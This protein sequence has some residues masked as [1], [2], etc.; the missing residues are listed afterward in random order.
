MVFHV[1]R[2]SEIFYFL[3]ILIFIGRSFSQYH[4]HQSSYCLWS[5]SL[6]IK[7]LLLNRFRFQVLV[8]WVPIANICPFGC[9]LLLRCLYKTFITIYISFNLRFYLLLSLQNLRYF[10]VKAWSFPNFGPHTHSKRGLP[11]F[12]F[13]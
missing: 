2:G 5:C 11:F 8:T 4:Q 1:C 10:Y 6:R 7:K 3:T 12:Y 9:V 13:L